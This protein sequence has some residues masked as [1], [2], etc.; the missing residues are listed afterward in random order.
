MATVGHHFR[1]GLQLA[2][3]PTGTAKHYPGFTLTS[4]GFQQNFMVGGAYRERYLSASSPQRIFNISEAKYVPSQIYASAPDQMV[5][6]TTAQA[7]L[8]GF[9][10]P[11]SD[12][13]SATPEASTTTLNNGT[14]LS[15]PLGGYQYVFLRGKNANSPDTIWI[16]GDDQCPAVERAAA[17]YKDSADYKVRFAATQSFYSQFWPILESV[18]D[19]S[20]SAANLTYANAF[21]IFDLINV[22]RIHNAT[23]PARNVSD[24]DMFQLRILADAAEFNANWNASNINRAIGARTLAGAVLAQLN[25]TVTSKGKLKFT[26]LAGSYDTFLGFFGL[27]GLSELSDDFK[28]LPEYASTMAFEL[29]TPT[30][31]TAFPA[32][33]DADLRVR[34]LFRNGTAGALTQWPLFA[35]E[36]ADLSWPNF[37]SRM[38]EFAITS[39]AEWCNICGSEA[40]FCAAYEQDDNDASSQN[41]GSGGI[42]NTVAG[43]VGAIVVLG[44]I[45]MPGLAAFL[46]VRRRKRSAVVD[47]RSQRSESPSV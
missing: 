5:L 7:F 38:Q 27:S 37:V 40:N 18:W 10:P 24:D 46:I 34:F 26:L 21:D 22:A 3:Y 1:P 36:N 4:L 6:L 20:D 25:Q 45:L 44:V 17:E 39:P 15:N 42:S 47:K 9:Y 23:S 28:G 30:T 29:F 33:P 14:T 16:K 8:Q 43:V 32:N 31:T 35:P 12:I 11:L 13:P 2:N 19:Y 41:V